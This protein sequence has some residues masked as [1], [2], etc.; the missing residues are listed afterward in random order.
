MLKLLKI[1]NDKIS[2]KRHNIFVIFLVCTLLLTSAFSLSF[3]HVQAQSERFKISGYILDSNGRGI[4][5]ADVIFNVPS[6]VPGVYTDNSGYYETYGP[7]GTYHINVWPPYDS[8]YLNGDEAG[9]TVTSDVTK[10]MTLQTGFKISGYVVNSIGTPMV[11]ASV[12]FK[13]SNGIYGS[14]YFTNSLGYYFINV[15]TGTYTIDAHPQTAFNPSY[16][17]PCTPFPTYY[18]YNFAVS[19]NINKNI[20]VGGAAPTPT[21]TPIAAPS[22]ESN[23]DDWSMFRHD[24]QRT[25]TTTSTVSNGMLLW[26]FNTGD[27]IRSSPAIVN[28]VVYEGSNNGI[29]YALN[30]ATGSVIWQYNSG[31]QVESSAAVVNGIVYVGILWDGHNGY[32]IALN[33]DTGSL[34]WRFSTNSG[35]ESSPTVVNGIVYIGSYYGYIYA[36]NAANGALIWSYFT[37]SST[38]SS[39]SIV[40]GILYQGA[41]NG[42]VYALNANNGAPIWSFQTGTQVYSTPAVVNDVVYVCS[43]AGIVFALR[44]SDGSKIWQAPIGSGTDHEDGSPAVAN[45][46][47]YIGA[48]NG[49]YALNT[50]NGAQIWF[51]TSP[52]SPRQ[53]TGYFYS[54][55]AVAGNEVYIGSIDGYLFALNAFNGSIIW[56]YRTGSFLFSSPAIVNG[57]LYIGSYDGCIYAL[58]ASPAQTTTLPPAPT[59]Q[60]T[61][62]STEPTPTATPTPAPTSQPTATPTQTPMAIQEP[63]LLSETQPTNQPISV[64]SNRNEPTNWI[65]LGA[66]VATA[67]IAIV[68]LLAVFKRDD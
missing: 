66:I 11:G 18:E 9:F 1:S 8:N 15:P 20:I 34:I 12:L 64:A 47:V 48:R 10:N 68:T 55:P 46:I 52:Y 22:N 44:A 13:T 51:F 17:G 14:G 6:I 21:P 60:P 25:G 65:I 4:A 24:V 3:S 39:P 42:N 45:G 23:L 49:Y 67:G 54:S 62:P 53:F 38:F 30:A 16:T 33:A 28:G 7:P 56:S 29:V 63:A 2:L 59:S 58:G 37:G 57:V 27:K 19:G 36:L 61:T 26:Q 40:N 31:S 43:D 32:V 41:D 5:K 35:I 50:T